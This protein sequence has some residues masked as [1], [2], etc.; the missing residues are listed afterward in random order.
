M[1]SLRFKLNGLLILLI[2]MWR[3]RWPKMFSTVQKGHRPTSLPL[4]VSCLRHNTP[5]ALAQLFQCL[6]PRSKSWSKSIRE[7][8]LHK[9]PLHH[10]WHAAE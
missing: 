5:E 8:Q 7:A 9:S 3:I 4:E 6:K 2:A 1:C 10:T